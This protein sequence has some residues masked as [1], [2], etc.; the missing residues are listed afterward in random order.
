MTIYEFYRA[1]FA[2]TLDMLLQSTI[3]K[4]E[5][6]VYELPYKCTTLYDIVRK[7][8]FTYQKADNKSIILESYRIVAWRYEYL[9]KTEKLRAEGY[10]I[11]CL[12]E[13]WFDSNETVRKV[14]A[15]STKNC[16]VSTLMSRGKKVVICH[17]KFVVIVL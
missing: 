7:L 9:R 15:D 1:K 11:I 6:T 8:G 2:P 16:S 10:L 17:A 13:T 12:D 14:W 4:T 5:G 3:T